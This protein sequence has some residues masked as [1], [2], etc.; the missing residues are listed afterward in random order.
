ME[1]IEKM[2]RFDPTYGEDWIEFPAFGQRWGSRIDSEEALTAV[3][4]HRVREEP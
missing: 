1:S 2:G 3:D 4:G